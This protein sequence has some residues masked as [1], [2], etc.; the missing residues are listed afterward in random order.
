MCLIVVMGVV[1][2]WAEVIPRRG[3]GPDKGTQPLRGITTAHQ[4]PPKHDIYSTYDIYD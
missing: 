1:D 2:Q 3:I 4:T